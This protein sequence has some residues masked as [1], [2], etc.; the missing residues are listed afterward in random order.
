MPTH[1][2]YDK[3]AKTVLSCLII[4]LNN[5]FTVADICG[6]MGLDSEL[7]AELV[8]EESINRFDF[9]A[10]KYISQDDSVCDRP[11]SQSSLS[12]TSVQADGIAVALLNS[13]AG[14]LFINGVSYVVDEG[15]QELT[16]DTPGEYQIRLESFPYLPFKAVIHAY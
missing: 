10:S 14:T 13:A 8:I 6:F 7:Y 12:A 15:S 11:L 2:V 5:T 16:F 4:P 9:L 3:A 1:I